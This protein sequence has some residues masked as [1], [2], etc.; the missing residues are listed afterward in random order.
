MTTTSR[1]LDGPDDVMAVHRFIADNYD[2]TPRG[3]GWEIR[4][5]EGQWWHRS[6][7]ELTEMLTGP[8]DDIRLWE[9]DGDLVAVAHPEGRGDA[10]MQIHPDHAGLA[11]E[12][13]TWA[14][15]TLAADCDHEI[16]SVDG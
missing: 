10:H 1:L 3:C 6:P 11:D 8:R 2:R 13:L 15:Q 4:R 5:W 14:E 7:E 16:D 9:V 12:M